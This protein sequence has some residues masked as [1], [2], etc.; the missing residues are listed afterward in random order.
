MQR[1]P[2]RILIVTD[3]YPPLIGG[4]TRSVV[5]LSRNLAE[6]GH[7]VAVATAWQEGQP[8]REAVDGVEVHR[9]RDLTSRIG[10]IS[11]DPYKHNP[12]PFPDPEA[13]GGLRRLIRDFGPDIVHAYGWLAHS[14]AAALGRREIP[15]LISARDYGNFCAV[16]TLIR[17]GEELCEGPALGKCIS[18]ASSHY[19]A[20]KGTVAACSVLGVGPLLRR[21]VTAIH[22]VSHFVAD[23]MDRHLRVENAPEV[24]I[25][26]FHEAPGD[27]QVDAEVMSRLPQEPF[28]LYVGAFRMI[29]GIAE[30]VAAYERL[31]EP[32]PLVLIGTRESDTPADFPPP[33]ATA[34]ER[35]PHPTVMAIWERALFGV[36]P[37]KAPEALGNVVLEGMSKGRPVVGTRP[38]GQEDLIEDGKSGF[39]VPSGDVGRLAEAMERL[40][41]NAE[42]REQMG[43]RA[44]ERSHDFTPEVVMPRLEALYKDTVQRFREQAA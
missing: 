32:P 12:P 6:R 44:L 31:S 25:P 36:L 38:G 43:R 13:I 42:L 5:L 35:V 30:L 7:A 3:S 10:W 8:A 22:S 9:V 34:L 27:A 17:K 20:A 19:G 4:A 15:L 39:L 41:E 23:Q 14:A 33:W 16:R 29:K 24:V 26:N 1:T 18:C 37:T 40:S 2:L 21:R 11:E 28:I